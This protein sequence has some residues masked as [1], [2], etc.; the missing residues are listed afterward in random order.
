MLNR[1]YLGGGT[2]GII[3]LRLHDGS[4][5]TTRYWQIDEDGMTTHRSRSTTVK[6]HEFSALVVQVAVP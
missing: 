1:S 2:G 3:R 6:T 4:N 5:G